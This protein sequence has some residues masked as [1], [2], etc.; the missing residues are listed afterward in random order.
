MQEYN[1]RL[2][3]KLEQR[4]LELEHSEAEARESREQLR[5]LATRLQVT[6]EEERIRISRE[7]HDDLGELLTGFKLGLAWIRDQLQARPRG[8]V[9]DQLLE[10]ISALGSL[11][12]STS[13]RIG[14]LM[15]KPRS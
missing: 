2:V 5:A 8:K 12:D 14:S 1:A 3:S 13:S 11:A 10:K 7:I 9:E 6:R 4:N 15:R